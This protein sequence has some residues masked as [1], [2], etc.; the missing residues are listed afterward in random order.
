LVRKFHYKVINQAKTIV[1]K[2]NNQIGFITDK[3]NKLETA[4]L[5]I[6]SNSLLN[7]PAALIQ[8][9]HVD[10][11]GCVW[12]TINKPASYFHESDHSFHVALNYYKKEIPF[13]LNTYGIAR[14]VTDAEEISRIPISVMQDF[15]N[16][17]LLVCVHILE[18]NYYEKE[19]KQ[20]LNIF[21]KCKQTL[22]NLF[23]GNNEY[24]DFKVDQKTFYA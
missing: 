15:T 6:H 21:Q 17:K 10:E 13:Y 24:Y 2:A 11:S 22:T 14:V 20:A 9:R 8:T 7:L 18:A 23:I 1:M 12:F 3:I 16:N 19:P 5:Q 4:I